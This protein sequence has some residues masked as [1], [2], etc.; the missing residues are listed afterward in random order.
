MSGSEDIRECQCG[1]PQRWAAKSNSPIEF[2]A[3]LNEFHLVYQ[4]AYGLLRYCFVCG[5]RLPESRRGELFSQPSET[6]V[7]EVRRLIGAAKNLQD[8][9]AA[10]GK[11][12]DTFDGETIR[13]NPVANELQWQRLLRY[14]SRW[15]TLVLDVLELPEGGI[16]YSVSGQYL[17]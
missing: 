12:D 1:E 13:K 8:V 16:T 3:R 14:S 15:K 11:P 5:G 9:L 2:D 4:G 6:E 7:E 10:L 17:G